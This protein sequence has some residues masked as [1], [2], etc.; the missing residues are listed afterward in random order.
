MHQ[1]L[2]SQLNFRDLGGIRTIDGRMV[3]PGILFRSG[4]L[5]S[6]QA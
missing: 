5:F 3:R 2:S 1:L 6:L 4:D